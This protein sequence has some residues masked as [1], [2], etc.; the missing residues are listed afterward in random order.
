MA[1]IWALLLQIEN[2]KELQLTI[3][4]GSRQINSNSVAEIKNPPAA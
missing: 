4:R 2:L 3:C 1:R